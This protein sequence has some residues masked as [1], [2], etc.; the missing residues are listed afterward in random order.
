MKLHMDSSGR[1][2]TPANLP[3]RVRALLVQVTTLVAAACLAVSGCASAKPFSMSAKR[4]TCVVLSVGGPD[5]LAHLG[6]LQAINDVGLEVDCVTGTSMGSLV[7]GLYASDP[8]ADPSERYRE[9]MATYVSMTKSDAEERGL[10]GALLLGGLALLTG[11]GALLVMGAAAV[12]AVGGAGT[13]DKVELE[14]TALAYD[15]YVKSVRV[16]DLPVSYATFYIDVSTNSARVTPV[17]TGPLSAGVKRSIANPIIFEELDP[18]TAGYVDPGLDRLAA[19]PIKDTCSLFPRHQIL[20][21]NVTGIPAEYGGVDCPV[22]E[23]TVDAGIPKNRE[24]VEQIM[25]G[26]GE[27]FERVVQAGYRATIQALER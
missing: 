21:I 12:G 8:D 10:A 3:P 15:S 18:R 1:R 26:R 13:V 24:V 5:G 27:Q 2:S 22:L 4:K 7:G 6:A 11:G 16:E 19:I 14:R 20:A 23:V 17:T 25:R 9:F